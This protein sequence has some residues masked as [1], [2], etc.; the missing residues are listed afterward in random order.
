MPALT[1]L[2]P[3]I[4]FIHYWTDSP[5][6]Q[7]R[8]KTIF[9]I[10]S[11]HEEY[12]NVF[13]AWN[14]MESGHGKGPCDPIGGTAKRQA[15]LAVKNEKAVIQDATDFFTWAK[16]LEETSAIKYFFISA[17]DYSN[18]A[19][20]LSKV[21]ENVKRIDGTMKIHAVQPQSANKLWVR[22]TSC[23]NFCCFNKG[24]FQKDTKCDGWWLADLKPGSQSVSDVLENDIEDVV[25]EINDYV[26]AVYDRRAYIG[27]VTE[28]DETDAKISFLEHKGDISNTTSFREPSRKDEIWIE[29]NNILCVL[30]EPTE[31]KRGRRLDPSIISIV[32][33][34]LRAWLTNG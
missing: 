23:Y 19:A 32:N 9:K 13:A 7:Y 8:N 15:D 25:L 10:T 4:Q 20:F 3:G 24:S 29:H 28:V 11:C 2:V 34:R 30:P 26:A 18:A 27:K 5:T 12:F 22:E 33:E 6:S 21:C 17:S 14:Y 31:T 1:Q 16:K